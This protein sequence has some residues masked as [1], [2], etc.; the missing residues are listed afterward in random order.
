MASTTH[1]SAEQARKLLIAGLPVSERI[2]VHGVSTAVLEGGH[3]SPLVL[4]QAEYGAVWMEVIPELVLTHHVVTPDLPG[5]GA[6]EISSGR[7]DADGVLSWLG[8]LI[9]RTCAS[10]PVLVG[11][12]PAGALA[13]RFAARH[14]GSVARLVLVDSHGL[15]RFRPPVGMILGFLSMLLRPTEQ[16]LERN[17]R[18]YCFVDGDQV[19]AR[20]GERYRWMTIYA[21]DRFRNPTVRTAMRSLMP[22]LSSPIPADYLDRITV[23]VTLIWG[24]HDV[25]VP[26]H[27]AE[28]AS[29]RYGWPLHV[30]EDARDDPAL[31]RPEEFLSALRAALT[32]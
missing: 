17:F 5:L 21:L 29:S 20:L 12:G 16:G 2:D 3:G 22:W 13:A 6:S 7:I 32:R 19:S 28:R 26:L 30:I 15:G 24:R 4:L 14:A 8:E 9:D 25:G 23:P 27:K 18:K 31:E 10:P 1:P 11:K